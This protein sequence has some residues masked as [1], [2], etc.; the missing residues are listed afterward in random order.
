M[1]WQKRPMLSSDT[2]IKVSIEIMIGIMS[3][4]FKTLLLEMTGQQTLQHTVEKGNYKDILAIIE[5]SLKGNKMII[6][7]AEG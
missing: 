1:E 4:G 6:C 5:E 2:V 3:L 7:M